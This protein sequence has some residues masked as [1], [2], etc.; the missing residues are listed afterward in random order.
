MPGLTPGYVTTRDNIVDVEKLIVIGD[1]PGAEALQLQPSARVRLL[2]QVLRTKVTVI[3]IAIVI[4]LVV[5]ALIVDLL[6]L[7]D[8]YVMEA[9]LRQPPGTP[10]HLLGTDD[11]GRDI[12][13]RVLHGSQVSLVIAFSVVGMGSVI[14][15]LLGLI[16]GYVGGIWD[17]LV[18]RIWDVI[19][20]FPGLLF[21][22]VI[23]SAL[24]AGVQMAIIALTIGEI[25][26]FGRLMRE[27]VLGQ[28]NRP[29][30]EAARAMGA[31]PWYIMLHHI[32]PNSLTPVLVQGA[33]SIP[34]VILAEAGLSYLGLGVPPPIPSWGKMIA[35]G[36]N[37]LETAPW[38]SLIPGIFILLATLGFNL[39]GDGLRDLFDPT[40]LN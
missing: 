19:F 2:K 33:L 38:I 12:L 30:V 28:Q 25:P 5:L 13:S 35:E 1:Q 39:L 8:P 23:M 7:E 36:Q 27:R 3:G 37:V 21:F 22:L 14:G 4:F 11:F 26:V 15:T 9:G 16:V 40:Q 34:G 29:Y 31:R 10:G 18:S 24:G 32:L 17:S 20:S 6:P